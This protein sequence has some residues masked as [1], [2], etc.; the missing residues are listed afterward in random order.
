METVFLLVYTYEMVKLLGD[1]FRSE[2]LAIYSCPQLEHTAQGQEDM[3]RCIWYSSPLSPLKPGAFKS[4][5][6]ITQIFLVSEMF[7]RR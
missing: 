5:H 4:P 7:S 6:K 1:R 2:K 3:W